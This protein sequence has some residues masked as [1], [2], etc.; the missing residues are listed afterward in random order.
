M[1]L[2]LFFRQQVKIVLGTVQMLTSMAS[3]VSLQCP[4]LFK[5]A[6]QLFSF[7]SLEVW[8]LSGRA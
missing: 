3:L 1:L 4:A 6:M 2:V 8:S 7:I 5:D